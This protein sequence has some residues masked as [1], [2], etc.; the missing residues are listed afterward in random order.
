[1]FTV[2][3]GISVSKI[4]IIAVK[5][6]DFGSLFTFK[7]ISRLEKGLKNFFIYLFVSLELLKAANSPY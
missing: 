1:M 7:D 4:I 6:E 3:N 2:S 5:E